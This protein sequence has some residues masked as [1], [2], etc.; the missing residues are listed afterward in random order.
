MIN[1]FPDQSEM[2]EKVIASLQRGNKSV[3]LQ[4]PTG[5]GKSIMASEIV[6][7]AYSK[8]NNVW[9]SVPR[10]ELIRQMSGTFLDFDIPHGHIAAGFKYN[11]HAPVNVCS[12]DT[13]KSRL[14]ILVAPK[15]AVIDEAH[16]GGDRLDTI[17]KWLK[18]KGTIILGLSA[19]PWK[20]SGQGLGCWYDDMVRGPSIRDL[21]NSGRLSDY[22]AFAPSRLDLSGIRMAGGDYAKGQL[23]DKMEN[24][25]VLIGNAVKH[26]KAHADGKLNIAYCVSIAHSEVTCEAFKAQGIPAAH[27]DGKTSDDERKRIITAFAKRELKVLTNCELLTFGFDLASQVN[28]DVT[29]E[30]MSDLRPT[31]SLA[32][33]MQKNGRVLRRKD[34][35]AIIFD[36]ANNVTEH[37]L[38]CE[39]RNW[40]LEDREVGTRRGGDKV[41]PVKHCWPGCGFCHK[42]AP[43]CPNCGKV[44]EVQS[45]EIEEVE[46]ELS[47]VDLLTI[48][49]EKKQEVWKAKSIA[50]LR[51]I[52]QKYGHKPGWV[53]I[54]A[55][56]RGINA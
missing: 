14:D 13:V 31:K 28:M 15:L 48:K 46:G 18:S 56:L 10:R 2:I 33:Q 24:D 30:C 41:M 7:R 29:V 12:T 8:G 44:Y 11:R 32:L 50:D 54:Q 20:L 42:P 1:L 40:T 21:I 26:Y 23:S 43:A 55:K 45:R 4:S 19:T 35:P 22:R 34:Y 38:P 36:H 49:R 51:A 5:S 53:H 47:E 37:G 3:L 16:F 25:R 39:E 27:I 6:R 17:I 9:F 52:Q